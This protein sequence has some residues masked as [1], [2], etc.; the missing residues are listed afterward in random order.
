MPQWLATFTFNFLATDM[1]LFFFLLLLFCFFCVEQKNKPVPFCD[2]PG[3]VTKTCFLPNTNI[4]NI[5]RLGK[6]LW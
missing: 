4:K 5:N 1:L 2:N 3:T 6:N